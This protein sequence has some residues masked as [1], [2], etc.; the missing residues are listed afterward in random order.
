MTYE[1]FTDGN[2][3]PRAK[4]SGFGGY[5]QNPQG[6][7]I[8]EFTEQVRERKYSHNFEI[9]GIIRG[10][11][12]A[13]QY[14]I[15]D[16]VSYC[17][18]KNTTQRLSEIFEQNIFA[19]SEAQKPELYQKV[20]E[21]SK[22]F[23]SISFKYIARENNKKADNLSRRYAKHMEDN[24]LRQ[25]VHDLD[26]SA[27]NL[28][29]N[30]QPKRRAFF[31][32]PHIMRLVHKNNPFLVAQQRGK[33][34]RK[35]IRAT[36]MSQ[37]NYLFI[38]Y[39]S[40]DNGLKL[41]SSLFNQQQEHMFSMESVVEHKLD[42]HQS[43]DA[44]HNHMSEMMMN[45]NKNFPEVKQLWVNSNNDNI[46]SFTEQCEKIDS[47][48]WD[49]FYHLYEQ[50]SLFD[51][52]VF[53]HLPFKPSLKFVEKTEKVETPTSEERWEQILSEYHALTNP[54]EKKR[55]VGQLI[56]HILKLDKEKGMTIDDMYVNNL[57]EK[58]E[59]FLENN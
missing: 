41:R 26:T 9:L 11:K 47:K 51:K 37:F 54:R 1:L 52:V 31:S 18:D 10:L 27:I 21:I 28:S 14:G 32:H 35:T 33:M 13:L 30:L 50:V 57:I 23:N 56:C 29:R 38:E 17:D 5:I 58:V 15:T 36:D 3:F 20:I 34:A 4:R 19:V 2:S 49:A 53:H 40:H 44:F 25:Y 59:T 6:E 46:M 42:E 8:M 22:E 45:I 7:I 24:W 39:Y 43:I 48:N 55:K 16:L 12:L